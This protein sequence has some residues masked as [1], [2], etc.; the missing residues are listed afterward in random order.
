MRNIAPIE[1]KRGDKYA[2]NSVL[3]N[4]FLKYLPKKS[5]KERG[6]MIYIVKNSTVTV[7]VDS[8]LIQ[9][10]YNAV[11]NYALDVCVPC[12]IHGF[13]TLWRE[14]CWPEISEDFPDF[15]L[16]SAPV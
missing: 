11:I 14:G 13:L 6:V 9:N 8:E 12:E 3:M 15:D 4:E 16:T 7:T 5:Y 1:F 10:S 2:T